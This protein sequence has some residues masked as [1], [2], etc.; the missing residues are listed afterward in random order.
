MFA[1]ELRNEDVLVAHSFSHFLLHLI[2]FIWTSFPSI[3][4]AGIV[5]EFKAAHSTRDVSYPK[6]LPSFS[7]RLCAHCRCGLPRPQN[8]KRNRNSLGLMPRTEARQPPMTKADSTDP[9]NSRNLH[10]F[11]A[12]LP[13]VQN[14]W[15]TRLDIKCA[16]NLIQF[17]LHFDAAQRDCTESRILSW[18]GPL[19]VSTMKPRSNVAVLPFGNNRRLSRDAWMSPSISEHLCHPSAFVLLDSDSLLRLSRWW[20]TLI[21]VSYFYSTSI[22]R[23]K[24]GFCFDSI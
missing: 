23:S 21:F 16:E 1:G 13:F 3:N 24:L 10:L 9:L 5:L 8:T 20:K 4:T 18:I 6:C 2:D 7:R 22:S 12:K 15:T 19:G 11:K 14:E 17:L